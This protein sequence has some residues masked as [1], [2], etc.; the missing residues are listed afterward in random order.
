MEQ[1]EQVE[2][3][4]NFDPIGTILIRS[5]KN[6]EISNSVALKKP[7]AQ[8]KKTYINQFD[9]RG[10]M[11]QDPDP[12]PEEIGLEAMIRPDCGS[13]IMHDISPD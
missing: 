7:K 6:Q 4:N 9:R 11:S 12:D 3:K 13:V 5:P 2:L 8:R 1:M 10:T